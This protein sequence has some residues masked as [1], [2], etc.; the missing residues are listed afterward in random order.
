M[1]TPRDLDDSDD[2][3]ELQ[4]RGWREEPPLIDFGDD[5]PAEMSN[6][7]EARPTD[8]LKMLLRQMEMEVIDSKP[9]ERGMV[10]SPEYG[11]PDEE[12]KPEPRWRAGRR[13]GL[14]RDEAPAEEVSR[15]PEEPP[16]QLDQEEDDLESPPTPP[17]RLTHPY[18]ARRREGEHDDC[19]TVVPVLT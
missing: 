1:P 13:L 16:V 14:R 4:K 19:G 9:T 8:R 11:A 5:I 12:V 17:I 10:S 18:S 6:Q 15:S 3:T 2:L 7:K